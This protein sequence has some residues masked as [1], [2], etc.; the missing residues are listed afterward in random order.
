MK[1]KL[2]LLL[3]A[4]AVLLSGCGK[5]N[6]TTE[7]SEKLQ[8]VTSFYP[9]YL[10]AQAVLE[11]AEGVELQNMAQPQTG[12]LHDY[13]LTIPDMKLLE[14]A[15]V[16][17]IN[18]GGMES[19]LEQALE[20]YPEL[21][22][23]DTSAG[24]ELME[25]E[26]HHHHEGEAEV[27]EDHTGHDHEG[28]PHIWLSPE[29]A[30]HQAENI[31]KALA[32]LDSAE[33]ELFM[34]NAETFHEEAHALQE[35]AHEISGSEETHAAVFHEGFA[36]LAE[37]FHMEVVFGVFA[38]EYEMPSAKELAEATDEAKAHGIRFFLTAEDNGKI[39]AETLAAELDE[40][41]VLLDPLT[42]ADEE[43]LS[44]L[45]RMERNIG[46]VEK[47]WKEGAE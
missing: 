10:L 26:E 41:I 28:N 19:F 33:A 46:I 42:T 4:L 14:G 11:G 3:L 8:V 7:H 45:E 40:A 1:K 43:G 16:L 34:A 23:V 44:Y 30:A 20:R 47:Y 39:Y 5:G 29:R 24:I 13:E 12:C 25:E 21:V 35:R 2:S 38:D 32:E 22:I 17:I 31:A 9:V 37:L 6:D 36:Y 18:G 27:K 15:D